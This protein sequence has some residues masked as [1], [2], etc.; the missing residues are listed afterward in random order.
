VYFSNIN[1]GTFVVMNEITKNCEVT[2]YCMI[3]I[4]VCRNCIFSFY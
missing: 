2:L 4:L 1:I 3:L